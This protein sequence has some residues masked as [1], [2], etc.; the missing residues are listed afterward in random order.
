MIV[1]DRKRG[2]ERPKRR[3][4]MDTLTRR[5]KTSEDG[6]QAMTEGER[7]A[8]REAVREAW[9][10]NRDDIM[11]KIVEIGVQRH[12]AEQNRK[13]RNRYEKKNRKTVGARVTVALYDRVKRTAKERGVSIYRFLVDLSGGGREYKNGPG[14][15]P[16]RGRIPGLFE[17][18]A[19]RK[20]PINRTYVPFP[21]RQKS[22]KRGRIG[23]APFGCASRG[24]AYILWYVFA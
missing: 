12:R 17:K 2:P 9:R 16:G 6:F 7:A 21:K 3:A 10:S 5:M 23:P 11:E 1:Y 14:V 19:A 4:K 8:M 15:H 20:S 22:D 24:R 18:H 13:S